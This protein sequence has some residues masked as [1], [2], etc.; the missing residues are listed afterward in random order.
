MCRAPKCSNFSNSLILDGIMTTEHCIYWVL[1]DS[2]EVHM[3]VSG[4]PGSQC[5]A[6]P[7]VV[8]ETLELECASEG[9]RKSQ[10][11]NLVGELWG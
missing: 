7:L 1:I 10:Q 4:S 2:V 9:E 5:S 8:C 11:A 3:W 6:S